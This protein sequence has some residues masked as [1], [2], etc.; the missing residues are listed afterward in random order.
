MHQKADR[1]RSYDNSDFK[2]FCKVND[3][4]LH[5]VTTSS[6]KGN[7]QIER[8]MRTLKNLLIIAEGNSNQSWQEQLEGIKLS[9]NSTRCRVMGFTPIELMFMVFRVNPLKFLKSPQSVT[10]L[11]D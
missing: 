10:I 2:D 4:E 11:E 1:S 3:I 8:V 6:S 7:R 9:L 5:L